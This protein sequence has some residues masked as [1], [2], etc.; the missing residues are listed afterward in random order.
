MFVGALNIRARVQSRFRAWNEWAYVEW[1]GEMY[2]VM[3]QYPCWWCKKWMIQF[4]E[5][6][7]K[8]AQRFSLSM[9]N[10]LVCQYRQITRFHSVSLFLFCS[11]IF[12]LSFS[13]RFFC[14]LPCTQSHIYALLGYR[15]FYDSVN[16]YSGIRSGCVIGMCALSSTQ[17][18][19]ET[20]DVASASLIVFVCCLPILNRQRVS[21]GKSKSGAKEERTFCELIKSVCQW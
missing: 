13:L 9:W 18:I 15:F 11:L 4:G 3:W 14:L 2:R 8:R 7:W 21:D 10:I 16:I 6:V 5:S 1:K 20:R 12:F 17:V 19:C